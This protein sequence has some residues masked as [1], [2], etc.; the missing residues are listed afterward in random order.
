MLCIAPIR[1]ETGK[2]K[3]RLCEIKKPPYKYPLLLNP[4]RPGIY[5]GGYFLFICKRCRCRQYKGVPI[6]AHVDRQS[7]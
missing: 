2:D 5:A 3:C 1:F 4:A 6:T 7:K